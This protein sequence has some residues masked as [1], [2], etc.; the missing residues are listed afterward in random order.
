MSV[1]PVSYFTM[2]I[3]CQARSHMSLVL[4]MTGWISKHS[5]NLQSCIGCNNA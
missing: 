1:S 3:E 4:S 5:I 2:Q